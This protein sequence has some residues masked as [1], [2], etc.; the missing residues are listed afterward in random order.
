MGGAVSRLLPASIPFRFFAAAVVYHLLGWIALGAGA[1]DVPRFAGGLGWP[2]AAL[3]LVTLGVLAMTA[4]GASLQ[5]LPVATRQAVPSKRWPA[6]IWW[7]Y[8]PGVAA[9]ALGMGIPAPRLLAG[10]AVAVIAALAGYALLLARNF[11]G[12]R[13]MPVVVAHGWAA[14]A[15]LL[16]VLASASSLAGAYVG[17]PWLG[18]GTALALHVSFAA[19]GFMGLLVL[20]LSYILVP[21][22]AL[23]EAPDERRARA[24]LG[25]ALAALLLSAAAASGMAPRPL[26]VTAI[27]A[28]AVAVALH[29]RLMSVA[30]ETGMRRTLGRSFTLVRM[31]WGMLAASLAT[32]LGIVLD[33]PFDGMAALFGLLLIGWLL[34]FH[35]GIL[36]RIV[37]FLASM[38][39]KPGRGRRPTPSSLTAERPLSIHLFCHVAAVAVLAA[40]ILGDSSRLAFAGAVLGTV[41]ALAFGTFFAS[42]VRRMSVQGINDRGEARSS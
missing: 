26:R 14:L 20:G 1:P 39:A 8:T 31:A 27:G 35:L 41:G 3:H 7:L 37:P 9:V 11:I 18:R 24:S 22:F 42:V 19:Y 40:A 13:G 36:Q 25:F 33:A 4:I 6:V 38:H 12:A 21:M 15:S 23:S 32:A 34:T 30:L 10:G 2:L 28:G 17:W 16:V 29:W 5:L